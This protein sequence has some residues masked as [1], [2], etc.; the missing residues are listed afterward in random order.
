MPSKYGF[1]TEEDR[2]R[3]RRE[4]ENKKAREEA[5]IE[6][7]AQAHRAKMQEIFR[8]MSGA[9]RDVL[10]DYATATYPHAKD[11]H[12]VT[13]DFSEQR[14]FGGPVWL[15]GSSPEHLL[16]Y[17][18]VGRRTRI[19]PVKVLRLGTRL[20]GETV[21]LEPGLFLRRGDVKKREWGSGYE[22]GW[23][24]EDRPVARCKV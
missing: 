12:K 2:E 22:D 18:G 20:G 10:L 9:V 21:E 14:G 15:L 4:V 1:D 6:A 13:E 23:E 19:E 7:Q 16:Y 8:R 11:D 3:K 5:R 24:G 17:V